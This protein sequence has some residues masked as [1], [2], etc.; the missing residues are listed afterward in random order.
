MYTLQLTL[1]LMLNMN[2]MVLRLERFLISLL[3]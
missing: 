1:R 3:L 2:L